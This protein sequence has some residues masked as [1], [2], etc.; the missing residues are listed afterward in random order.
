MKRI[1]FALVAAAVL[2]VTIH[3][4]TST[5]LEKE[6]ARAE[7]ATAP[8]ALDPHG[9][10]AID[11]LLAALDT[12][13]RAAFVLTQVLGYSYAETAE[14]CGVRIGTVR[15]R[16]ARAR[17]NLVDRVRAADADAG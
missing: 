7:A 2:F 12:D 8:L 16:I 5:A 14:I 17:A 3:F 6:R 10:G 9:R 13:Q 11:E 4:A 15:S 1:L